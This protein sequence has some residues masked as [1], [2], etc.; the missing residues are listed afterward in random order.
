MANR[1]IVN[2]SVL[3]YRGFVN[4][5]DDP[6]SKKILG[7]NYYFFEF[8]ACNWL[9]N[10]LHYQLYKGYPSSLIRNL[11]LAEHEYER[12][13]LVVCPQ[14]M[15]YF[16]KN[17]KLFDSTTFQRCQQGNFEVYRYDTAEQIEREEIHFERQD[18][19]STRDLRI[20]VWKRQNTGNKTIPPPL[21]KDNEEGYYLP[22][23]F[24]K[25]LQTP[26]YSL[27][28]K[29]PTERFIDYD[30]YLCNF[31]FFSSDCA[32]H[33]ATLRWVTPWKLF[34]RTTMHTQEEKEEEELTYLLFPRHYHN[35]PTTPNDWWV[36]ETAQQ[37][38]YSRYFLYRYLPSVLQPCCGGGE[39]F[40]LSM[41][42]REWMDCVTEKTLQ[43][44]VLFD[45]GICQE[46]LHIIPQIT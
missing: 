34:K 36:D 37:E 16:F 20:F 5:D 32:A 35:D 23:I 38:Q 2:G 27:D 6:V 28:H 19:L 3:T 45:V 11:N 39:E 42:Q 41:K 18:A 8:R 30:C 22:L 12:Q 13:F 25:L 29:P 44:H 26:L 33:T 43:E 17:D 21:T 7:G 46:I 15:V 40:Y 14:G 31:L 1:G 9:K 10:D 4:C 24:Q